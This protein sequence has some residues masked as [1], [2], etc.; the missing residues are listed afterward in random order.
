MWFHGAAR[1]LFFDMN[2]VCILQ[3]AVNIGFHP[4][5]R[6]TV[7]ITVII[8]GDIV[9]I[10]QKLIILWTKRDF[11]FSPPILF[12]GR[13]RTSNDAS[14][15]FGGGNGA[16]N[17]HYK[18]TTPKAVLNVVIW[19][20]CRYAAAHSKMS[21]SQRCSFFLPAFLLLLFERLLNNNFRLQS[22]TF[23]YLYSSTA[24]LKGN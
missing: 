18:V 20:H 17:I 10:T 7:Y 12:N 3:Y 13:K 14:V 22:P 15:Q 1:W 16:F 4:M 5:D 8:A 6:I 19:R 2:R 21:R 11:F 24:V 23:H 9:I